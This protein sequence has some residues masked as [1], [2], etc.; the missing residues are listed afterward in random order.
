MYPFTVDKW[1]DCEQNSYLN[2]QPTYTQ[3]VLFHH[4]KA[5][6]HVTLWTKPGPSSWTFVE[7]F[8]SKQGY[9]PDLSPSIFP[10][11]LSIPITI[12]RQ[13]FSDVDSIKIALQ[14][15]F[16][17]KHRSVLSPWNI[18]TIRQTARVHTWWTY[19]QQFIG[20]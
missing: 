7:I 5:K 8:R 4:D 9:S 11:F 16:D 12:T 2:F 10:L 14:Q 15:H 19:L 1:T 17:N 13:T 6:T 20:T 18:L 3:G